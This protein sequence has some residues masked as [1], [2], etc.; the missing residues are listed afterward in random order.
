MSALS[1]SSQG[2]RSRQ[3][4][5]ADGFS[6]MVMDVPS[7]PYCCVAQEGSGLDIGDAIRDLM[8]KSQSQNIYPRGPVMAVFYADP[9]L[10]DPD[11]LVWEVG[12]PCTDQDVPQAPL[13]KRVWFMTPVAR[14][15]TTGPY[16][17]THE[18]IEQLE[19][20]MDSQGLVA[21]GPIAE[22]Y[23][24]VGPDEPDTSALRTE[25][26][27]PIKETTSLPRLR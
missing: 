12:F 9:N 7:F 25:I 20:W 19:D 22:R 26:W 6:A 17:R 27:I 11:D 24:D 1:L 18:A 15:V 4:P 2:P 13:F 5:A 14:T 21:A 23:L 16:W 3:G 10:V 8:L